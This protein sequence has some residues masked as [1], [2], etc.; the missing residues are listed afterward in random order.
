MN[1]QEKLLNPLQVLK[2]ERL[3]DQEKERPGSRH[4]TG[5]A[6]TT[7]NYEEFYN[8]QHPPKSTN[9]EGA[10]N[11]QVDKMTEPVPGQL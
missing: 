6:R 9:M 2:G 5:H 7:M 3:D 4:I 8:S 10:L 11:S 1:F